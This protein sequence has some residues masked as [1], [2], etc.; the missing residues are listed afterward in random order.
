M[1]RLCKA[2]VPALIAFCAVAVPQDR[3]PTDGAPKPIKLAVYK[4]MPY[5]ATRTVTISKLGT[6][7]QT[8]TQTLRSLLWR[9]AE[10]KTRQ[11]D[12]EENKTFGETRAINVDDPVTRVHYAWNDGGRLDKQANGV[13]VTHTPASWQE[14]D[15]WPDSS[16]KGQPRIPPT[17]S[18]VPTND[19]DRKFE[20]LQPKELSGIHVEGQRITW[21]IPVGREGNDRE[22]R[23]I[24]E[25]W[26]SPDLRIT[27]YSVLDDSRTGRTVIEL[28]NIDRSNPAPSIFQPPTDRPMY[29]VNAV[30]HD[31]TS[32][33]H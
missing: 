20:I 7:G 23:V 33:S 22:I 28:T 19:P 14:E 6:D 21:V 18:P 3:G 29:D 30:G 4:E 5:S 31:A 8:T 16:P 12:I 11:D 32:Q 24:Q 13:M 9:D 10:G 2:A 26:T 25:K 27:I 1:N 15:F 17:P